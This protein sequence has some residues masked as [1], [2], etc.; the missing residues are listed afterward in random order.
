MYGS[1]EGYRHTFWDAMEEL[2]SPGG[3]RQIPS[4][5]RP[6]DAGTVLIVED[7]SL[8]QRLYASMFRR[9]GLRVLAVGGGNEA[10]MVIKEHW[11]DVAVIDLSLPGMDGMELIDALRFAANNPDL[12][13]VVVSAVGPTRCSSRV[14]SPWTGCGKR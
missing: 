1:V 6:A 3:K 11:I 4:S 13:I 14:S 5:P 7:S 9:E 10:L 2:I 8:L 12:R